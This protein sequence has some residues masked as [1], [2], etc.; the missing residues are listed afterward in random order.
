[1]S[2]TVFIA[3]LLGS[4]ISPQL[5]IAQT[6]NSDKQ[7]TDIQNKIS[8]QKQLLQHQKKQQQQ[9]T[10]QLKQVEQQVAA[11]ATALH[12]TKQKQ[13]RALKKQSQL[14]Q[15]QQQ[16]LSQR[17]KQQLTLS[18]QIKSAYMTGGN[19]LVKLLLNQQQ[20]N[21]NERLLGYYQYL[22]KARINSLNEL[23]QTQLKLEKLTTALNSSVLQLNKLATVQQQEQKTLEKDKTKRTQSLKKLA[24]SY[25]TSSKKLEQYQLSELDINQL[26]LQ[27]KQQ[28]AASQPKPLTGLAKA[29]GRLPRPTKGS[30]VYKFGQKR[31]GQLRWK[32]ITIRGKEGQSVN[33]IHHGKVIYSDWIKGFGLVLAI[34]H[35]NGY[36]SLYGHNQALLKNAGEH[37]NAN[38]QIALLGQSGGQSQPSLYFEM[39]FKGKAINPQSWLKSS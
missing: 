18:K 29:K 32:G 24:Q 4:V 26:L 12:K 22:N 36:M 33:A 38:E 30:L 6:P 28:K 23:K 3:L 13:Q 39:R 7:L 5:A 25:K 11:S 19:D 14:E 27:A 9:L 35:G 37:V 10:N 17:S 31:L 2:F 21:K 15:Q 34:D 20:S 8:K 1:M 16:L